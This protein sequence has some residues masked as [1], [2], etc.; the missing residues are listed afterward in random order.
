M[1]GSE[2]KEAPL[3]YKQSSPQTILNILVS[4]I[5]NSSYK[6]TG[7]LDFTSTEEPILWDTGW[8]SRILLELADP[9]NQRPSLLLF[10]SHKAKDNALRELFPYN[11][12]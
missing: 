6:H 5:I 12:F 11:N 4:K 9:I 1:G 8:L 2:P 7:W 10:I 3:S